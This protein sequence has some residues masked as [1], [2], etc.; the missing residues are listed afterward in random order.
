MLSRRDVLTRTTGAVISLSLSG[1]GGGGGG[2]A[3]HC[4]H[5]GSV[6]QPPRSR[7]PICPSLVVI[8]LNGGNDGLNTVV[9]YA[10]DVYHKSRPT[11]R[12]AP[13]K[14][15]KLDDH[16]GLHPAMKDL[17]RLWEEG[18][19]KVVQN[20]GYPNPNRSHFR[21]MQ[22]W[23]AGV[24]GAV[25]TAGWLGRACDAAP[26]L[27]RCFVGDDVVPLALQGRKEPAAALSNLADF[28][29]ALETLVPASAKGSDALLDEIGKR[30]QTTR[31]LAA[32]RITRLRRADLPVAP[33]GS[34]EER[35][36]T[37]RALLEGVPR[38]RI[39]Y[40]SIGGF[41]THIGQQFNHQ[42][43]LRTVSTS[44]HRFMTELRKSKL[45]DRVVVLIYSEFGRRLTENGQRGTDHGTAAPLF[46]VGR[47]LKGGLFGP[48]PDL[49]D[50]ELG[51]PRYKV[52]FR[53]I[54][55]TMLKRWL[56][57]DPE[58]VLGNRDDA[59]PLLAAR[60]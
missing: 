60:S 32:E 27:G 35:L 9:P 30:M 25:P 48:G 29:P 2:G 55:P 16:V 18:Q 1:G 37:I 15:L 33:A 54:Y 10:D 24:L 42:E 57:I 59:A 50:L 19:V 53:D 39:F 49:S 23:H 5:S 4:P 44:V 40:T 47:P 41:D 31:D 28:Q 36:L 22:I 51:D 12:I 56:R 26:A 45:D 13:D 7:G 34:L 46:L 6:S 11:L 17:H 38:F 3:C 8:G 58:P 20:A 52:D 14:V 43:L 21:S